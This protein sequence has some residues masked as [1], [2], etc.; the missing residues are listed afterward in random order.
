MPSQ[1]WPG[2]AGTW[3]ATTRGPRSAGSWSGCGGSRPSPVASSSS[4]SSSRPRRRPPKH[5]PGRGWNRRCTAARLDLARRRAA[6]ESFR[7]RLRVLVSTDAGS[8]GQNLQ[9]AWRLVN[10]DLPWNPMRVEQ[11]I[12]RLHRLGQSRPVEVVNLAVP[13]T[14]EEYVLTL[15]YEKLGMFREVVGDLDE[16]VA[17]VPGGIGAYIGRLVISGADDEAVLTGLR[18]LGGFLERQ[19]RRWKRARELTATVLDG[20]KQPPEEGQEEGWIAWPA[21]RHASG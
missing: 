18:H 2:E 7:E 5:W 3:P 21:A 4:P 15:L 9:W 17:T 8:E 6:L 13:G 14:I 16:V 11:R 1:S 19:W 10:L 12:G 20:P